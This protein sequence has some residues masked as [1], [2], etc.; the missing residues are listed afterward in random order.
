MSDEQI[1]LLDWLA[2]HPPG[3][4]EAVSSSCEHATGSEDVAPVLL[5]RAEA[6]IGPA[7]WQHLEEQ[8]GHTMATFVEK[9]VRRPIAEVD[10]WTPHL[11]NLG[12]ERT[13]EGGFVL[14]LFD[15]EATHTFEIIR[16]EDEA[17]AT[18]SGDTS[19][20]NSN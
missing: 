16:Q 7:A 12:M 19:D 11:F 13:A 17:L 5:T 9:Y 10:Q 20:A 6:H 1:D 4:P 18:D 15:Q 14:S 2:A 3:A 8:A